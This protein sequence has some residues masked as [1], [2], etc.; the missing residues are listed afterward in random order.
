MKTINVCIGSACHLKGSYKVINGLQK[1]IEERGLEDQ[2]LV[3]ASF[4][5]GECTKAVSVRIDEG[6]VFSVNENN[7]DE[8]FN[9]NI[10]RGF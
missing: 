3:K 5:L 7:I 9:E 6:K 2:V 8:F 4:C 1:K 10:D